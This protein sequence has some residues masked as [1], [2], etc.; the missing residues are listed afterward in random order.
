MYCNIYKKPSIEE[1]VFVYSNGKKKYKINCPKC[2]EERF[3]RMDTYK[4]SKFCLCKKCHADDKKFYS[5]Y[6]TSIYSIW[7]G[8][9]SRCY[10]K[11]NKYYFNYGGRGIQVCEE[12]LNSPEVFISW[13]LLNN[14][15]KDLSIDRI[16]NDGNYEPTNCRWANRFEQMINTREL[17]ITNKTGYKNISIYKNKYRVSIVRNRRRIVDKLFKNIDEAIEF[18]DRH[19][20]PK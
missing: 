8:M 14:Y 3:I 19:R 1:E 15:S 13:S 6:N 7:E 9:K 11:N 18:R 4:E 12:W 5:I 17:I 20:E 16:N 10:N 2:M